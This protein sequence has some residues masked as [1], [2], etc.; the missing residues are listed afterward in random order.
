MADSLV[1]RC[2]PKG[3]GESHV[4]V[5]RAHVRVDLPPQRCLRG[6]RMRAWSTVDACYN[7]VRDA[8]SPARPADSAR[9]HPARCVR[10]Q[11]A[12]N[13]ISRGNLRPSRST[14][15][16]KLPAQSVMNRRHIPRCVGG[17]LKINRAALNPP[18]KIP[19]LKPPSE[20]NFRTCL[21]LG[22]FGA[23]QR[24]LKG[25][26]RAR[27]GETPSGIESIEV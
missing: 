24:N 21:D 20:G 2:S 8:R 22:H 23:K 5:A 3:G 26:R 14:D 7:S 17:A 6:T 13:E 18:P 19:Y 16:F 9:D 12:I 11:S 15:L 4:S 10:S 27:W 1:C 25:C